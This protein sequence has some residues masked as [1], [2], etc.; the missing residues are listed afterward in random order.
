MDTS[1]FKPGGNPA[2]TTIL[3]KNVPSCLMLQGQEKAL[4]EWAVSPDEDLTFI[5]KGRSGIFSPS[6][7]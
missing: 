6:M 7:D 1:E 2:L 4:A 5:S 3:S